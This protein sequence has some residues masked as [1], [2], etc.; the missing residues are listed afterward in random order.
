MFEQAGCPYCAAWN[1]DVGGIY[2]KTD[3]AL[4]LPLRRIDIHAARPVDLRAIGGVHFTPRSSSCTAAVKW[5]GSPAIRATRISGSARSR[6]HDHQRRASV[7]SLKRA[8][9]YAAGVVIALSAGLVC[10]SARHGRDGCRKRL[11][12]LYD[13]RRHD[14]GAAHRAAGSAAAGKL[15]IEDRK[16][17]NCLSCHAM[18]LPDEDQGNVGPDLHTV[19]SRLKPASFAC[20]S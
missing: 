19:G 14:T 8:G 15:V 13:R 4:V 11:A 7:P 10:G 9:A 16:L 20:A 18:A 12:G 6:N 5:R 17:G 2:A 3:E 1:H